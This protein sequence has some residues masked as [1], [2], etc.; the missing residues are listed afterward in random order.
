[1][2]VLADFQQRAAMVAT[3]GNVNEILEG[4]IVLD[5]ACLD[6]IYRTSASAA[7]A[8]VK[9]GTTRAWSAG[10]GKKTPM[11]LYVSGMHT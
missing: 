6:R 11:A 1:M 2:I 9:P 3:V 5:L 10:S 4:Q 7:T 8:A